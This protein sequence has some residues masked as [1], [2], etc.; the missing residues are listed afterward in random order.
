M[1]DS[2]TNSN[3]A[4]ICVLGFSA[5]K[6]WLVSRFLHFLCSIPLFHS[7]PSGAEKSRDRIDQGP[8][9]HEF[10]TI[11]KCVFDSIP[12]SVFYTSLRISHSAT[13]FRILYVG[14]IPHFNLTRWRMILLL[15]V[16]LALTARHPRFLFIL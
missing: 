10:I 9:S 8:N 14:F 13:P 2:K 15:T 6:V 16:S 7:I 5:I 12:L 4:R 1:F 11:S 3:Q